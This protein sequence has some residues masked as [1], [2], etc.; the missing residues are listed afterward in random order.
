MH[1]K[2][3]GVQNIH[4]C[5]WVPFLWYQS[6]ITTQTHTDRVCAR[7][8]HLL[9]LKPDKTKTW[10]SNAHI[11]TTELLLHLTRPDLS[12]ILLNLTR[13]GHLVSYSTLQDPII[14]LLLNLTRPDH[15]VS[16]LQDPIILSQPYKTRSSCLLLNVTWSTCN[17]V[18]SKH[19]GTEY[20]N[21]SIED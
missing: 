10:S 21:D 17:H 11:Y 4:H 8:Q 9:T 18:D 7:T 16:T 20:L 14:C 5:W 15:L 1:K 12:C 6:N 19:V 3:F 2:S 13:P